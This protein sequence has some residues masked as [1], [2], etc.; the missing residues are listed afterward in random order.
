MD[1][2]DFSNREIMLMF[3][4]IKTELEHI[5]EQTTRT[6]GRLVKAEDKIE[7]LG[8]F[9]TRV[10]TIWGVLVAVGSVVVNKF[11]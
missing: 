1:E 11:L 3:D 8:T 5:K 6:N 7:G 4:K 9:Q 2:K 10:L